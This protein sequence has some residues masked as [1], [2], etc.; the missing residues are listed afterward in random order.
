MIKRSRS[1]LQR[2]LDATRYSWLGLQA[3]WRSEQAFRQ[4]V[5]VV[6]PLLPVSFWLGANATQRALLLFSLL[7][8]PIV[9][10]LNSGIEAVVDRFGE[11]LHPLCGQAKDM[12]SAAVLITLIAAGLTWALIAWERFA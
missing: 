2:L 7:L 4:E 8:I 1:G 10:L 9:E 11:E 3:A 12:G 5:Y 6:V